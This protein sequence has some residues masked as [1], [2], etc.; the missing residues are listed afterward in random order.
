MNVINWI[1]KFHKYSDNECFKF[2][3]YFM[4]SIQTI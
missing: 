2:K 3:K 1:D 4:W